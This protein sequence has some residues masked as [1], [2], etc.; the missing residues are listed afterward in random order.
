MSQNIQT[1]FTEA[2]PAANIGVLFDY[3]IATRTPAHYYRGQTKY[4]PVSV[5]SAMRWAVTEASEDG[6]NL[7][8]DR[9]ARE[10]AKTSLRGDL[11]I[12]FGRVVGNLLSRQY[13]VA[14]D[15]YDITS[16]PVIAAF[17]A[18]RSYPTY[19]SFKP[20]TSADL[21]VIY[22]FT[23]GTL[24][25]PPFDVMERTLA[26][27]YMLDQQRG[28]KVWFDDV[29]QLRMRILRGDFIGVTRDYF[30]QFLSE[31]FPEGYVYT[32][33]FKSAAYV[34]YDMIEYAF[35]HR[36][37]EL[38]LSNDSKAI[39]RSSRTRRQSGGMYFPPTTHAVY[40]S[41][42]VTP[43]ALT[44]PL[45]RATGRDFVARPGTVETMGAER[46]FNLNANPYV[47]R[48]YFRHDPEKAVQ[49]DDL[50]T[51][52]PSE[53]SDYLLELVVELCRRTEA[54]RYLTDFQTTALDFEK[55][56]SDPGYLRTSTA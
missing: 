16:D 54:G 48:F 12:P 27:L 40:A 36:A 51:L 45:G 24:T 49:V 22:R 35:L 30:E 9:P 11:L 18:T 2:K 39:I 50:G 53:K 4:F 37:D 43:E 5:P 13:G 14:S 20:V 1:P 56:V 42:R 23:I 7:G 46:V 28:V 25:T 41:S 10:R 6:W 33:L 34:T 17:F 29:R 15:A 21:G 38:K 19:E 52:W 47:E 32:Q 26:W 55:G 3:L 31:R 44:T 8:I